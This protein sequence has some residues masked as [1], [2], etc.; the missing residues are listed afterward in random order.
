MIE[1]GC[2]VCGCLSKLRDMTEL[3]ISAPRATSFD[4]AL[5]YL[6]SML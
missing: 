3:S 4:D 2:A 5:A 6:L 1:E